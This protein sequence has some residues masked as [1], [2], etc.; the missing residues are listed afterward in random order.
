MTNFYTK[1]ENNQ[2]FHFGKFSKGCPV[3]LRAHEDLNSW[4]AWKDYLKDKK[5]MDE[6]GYIRDYSQF[7]NMIESLNFNEIVKVWND[8]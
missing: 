7:V 6:Y 8:E 5:I 3:V 1:Q 2:W 4:Q